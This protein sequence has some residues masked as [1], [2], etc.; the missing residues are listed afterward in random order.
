VL[1][2]QRDG[3]APFR[4]RFQRRDHLAGRSVTTTL[5]GLPSGVAEGIDAGGALLVR[6][7]GTLRSV[8]AGDVS[9]RLVGAAGDTTQAAGRMTRAGP[10][11]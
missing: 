11:A 4:E 5:E 7:D 8:S 1:A 2:F 3:F 9:V 10:S 6:A